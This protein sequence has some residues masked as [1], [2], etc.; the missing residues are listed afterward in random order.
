MWVHFGQGTF[1]VVTAL[2]STE[3]KAKAL[4]FR[5]FNRSLVKRAVVVSRLRRIQDR[6]HARRCQWHDLSPWIGLRFVPDRFCSRVEDQG[7]GMNEL[8][9]LYIL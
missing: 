9:H 3:S 6:G 1:T 7:E 5:P 4:L 2:F 8:S